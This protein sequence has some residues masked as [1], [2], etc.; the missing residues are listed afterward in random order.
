M[1]PESF[2]I[3][4][5]KIVKAY[6]KYGDKACLTHMGADGIR[7]YTGNEVADEIE[8]ETP[9]GVHCI[10]TM[11]QL[12]IDLLSRD[13]MKYEPNKLYEKNVGKRVCKDKSDKPF[14]SGFKV[15]TVKGVI[16]H[17]ILH[18]PAYTFEEDDSYVE[19]RRCEVVNTLSE[20]DDKTIFS[21]TK[22]ELENITVLCE[23]RSIMVGST[24]V[25]NRVMSILCER[26]LVKTSAHAH[27]TFWE[28]TGKGYDVFNI[29]KPI[30]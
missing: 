20:P 18:V 29:E 2:D 21:F 6:R 9:F 22:E 3:L 19:C 1:K 12:T 5:E 28:M 13:K 17:P 24:K 7:Q 14:K 25:S 23:E 8:N 27:G 10:F 16:D 11:L 15:N 30:V 26:G 4:K